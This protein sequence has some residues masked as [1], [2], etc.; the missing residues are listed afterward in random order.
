M[1]LVHLRSEGP[2]SK[3]DSCYLNF[4]EQQMNDW[5]ENRSLVLHELPEQHRS[6]LPERTAQ[7]GEDVIRL[8]KK[9]QFT[10]VTSRLISQLVAAATSVGANYCEADDSVSNKEFK[11]RM[12]TC[13]KSPKKP[14]SSYGCLPLPT[15]AARRTLADSGAKQRN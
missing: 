8:V 2:E 1:G 12:G 4:Q 10:P 5:N 6:D 9:V 15:K 13:R 11:L 7:F 3:P 14:C